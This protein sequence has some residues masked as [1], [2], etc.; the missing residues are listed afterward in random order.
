MELGLGESVVIVTGASSGIGRA[1]AV[2]FAR[3]G[4]HVVACARRLALLEEL[5]EEVAIR[6]EAQLMPLKA[7]V[8]QLRDIK[9]VVSRT[10]SE[11]GRIDVLV[12]NAGAVPPGY[13]WEF[14]DR[15]WLEGQKVKPLGYVRFCR[16]VLPHMRSRQ[17]GIIMNMAG[18][19][20]KHVHQRQALGGFV[21]PA[22][23][24]LTKHLA[25]Q[26][27]SVGIRVVAVAPGP[28]ATE[29]S[30]SAMRELAASAGVPVEEFVDEYVHRIPLGR[31]G[32]PEEVANTV[33]FLC[34]ERAS[35]VTGC[36]L[37]VDGGMSRAMI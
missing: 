34:S 4:A 29:R 27:G 5:R 36:F 19:G 14:S 35:F 15:E 6:F 37:M 1:I 25:D 23:L 28:T 7:D 30:S 18:V 9:R 17:S 32:E 21:S 3:E 8:A 22:I 20:A 13:L 24:G 31:F 11:F 33:V 26:V 12:N 2:A 16:E 10:L